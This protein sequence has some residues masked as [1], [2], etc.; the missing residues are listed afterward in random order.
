MPRLWI[1]RVIVVLT[2]ALGLNYVIWRWFHSVNWGA[3][4]IGLPLVL[5]ETYALVDSMLFGFTVWKLRKRPLPPRPRAG[6]SVDVFITTYNEPL[7][8][9]QRTALAAQAITYP[10][11]TWLLDDGS[12]AELGAWAEENGIG[13]VRRTDA[14]HDRPR[15][16]KAGNV[17]NALM[18]TEGEFIL[19]LDAD[20]VPQ[21]NVL[22][23]TLGYFEDERMALVQT[24]QVFV[25]VPDDDPLG[26]QAPLFYGPIQQGK[27][28]WNAAF[29]C[30]SNAIIRR[31]ALMQ[32]GV[33]RYAGE[34]EIGVHRALRTSRRVLEQARKELGTDDTRLLQA[35]DQVAYDIRR[36]RNELRRDVAIADVTYRF[37]Q[38]VDAIARELASH[39]VVALR[40]D[41]AVIA[42]LSAHLGESD[43]SLADLAEADLEA[44]VHRDW[45]PLGAL[46]TVSTLVGSLDMGRT[47]EAQPVM[48]LATI[49]VTEDMATCMRL[50]ALGWSSAYHHETLVHGLAPEDLG[51][52]LTQRLRWAQGTVQVMF[53]ENPLLLK[54]LSIPQR[55]MYWSTMWSYLSGFA[56][57]VFVAAP[58]IYLLIGVL[59]VQSLATEFFVR[60]IPFLVLNQLLFFIVGRG[61]KTWR[62]QQYSLALFPVWIKSFTTAFGNVFLGRE[63]DFSVTPKV[64]PTTTGPQWHLIKPQLIAMALLV[65]AAVVGLV[66]LAAG[67]ASVLGTSANLVWVVF[68]LLIFSVLIRAAL[69]RGHE[70]PAHTDEPVD[71]RQSR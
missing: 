14:W 2:V 67:Q 68:D 34:I 37:Q 52:M 54:G 65:V 50:H 61:V 42:E 9:V 30:G 39:D 12:R 21:P 29:F 23:R 44:V 27:D 60:L 70:V 15:H 66:R 8:L 19:I 58:A 36:A 5:A 55:L 40:A 53:R 64:R 48:P 69:Y 33:S 56:A 7:E 18:A 4:W 62:G 49:S 13:W 38:R 1:V 11:E 71:E 24:P 25:N 6:L 41:L 57:V 16:A 20:Q 63:L 51:T 45:S 47:H 28:A 17:N 35:L 59:P 43:V 26:S 46:Q 32:L 10:H 22:D 31:E 3:W